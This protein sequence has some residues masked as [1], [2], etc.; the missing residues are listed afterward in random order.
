MTARIIDG[1]AI[2]ASIRQGLKSEVAE[3][4]AQGAEPGLAV[5]LVGENP[6]SQVYVR[7]KIRACAEV[8]IRS[9][10]K[11][12]PAETSEAELLSLIGSLNSDPS[13]DGILVQLPLPRH[14]S[15][16]KV[17]D[18]ISPEKDV[19]G[20]H[21]ESAGRLFVGRKGFRPCTPYGIMK[22]LET[23]GLTIDGKK[24]VVVGR[25]NI[26]GKPM[27]QLMMQKQYGDATVTVC[28]S[29]SANLKQE[30]READII[31]AAIGRP[32]FVTADMVKEG[33]VVIDVGTTRVPDATRKSGFRLSG[34][35]DFENVAPHC[36]F[37]TPVPGGVGPMTICSL[38]KNTLS[39]GKH[40][41]YK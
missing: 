39:A 24:A 20:F 34:D 11:R 9:I 8:G 16:E 38:M 29:H 31:I 27:A 35:V 14:I 1:K 32:G 17:I 12:L 36:S 6:A 33:A 21:V 13:V 41:F 7:N 10:E 28:H 4:A 26:V 23:T 15:N 37:I 5:I 30:C 2:A 3:L 22:L 19:D 25:S 18:A 40:E